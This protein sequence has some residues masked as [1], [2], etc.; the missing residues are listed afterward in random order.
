MLNEAT[1]ESCYMP[2]VSVLQMCDFII[3]SEV[4]TLNIWGL[5]TTSASRDEVVHQSTLTFKFSSNCG[6][7]YRKIEL[8]EQ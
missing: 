8:N 6:Q 4:N 3:V 5:R 2:E 7:Y 1:A